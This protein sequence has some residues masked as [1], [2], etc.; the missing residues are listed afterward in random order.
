MSVEHFSVGG[1]LVLKKKM[2]KLHNRKIQT[3]GKNGVR[4]R[5]EFF[6]FLFFTMKRKILSKMCGSCA[7]KCRPFFFVFR[8]A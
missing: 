3:S 5:A 6:L 2:S 8:D 4:K 7:Y 1:V